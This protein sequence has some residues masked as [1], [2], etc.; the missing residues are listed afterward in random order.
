[1]IIRTMEQ[2]L[3]LVRQLVQDFKAQEA[4]YLSPQYQESQVRQDFIDKFFTALGWDVTHQRQKNPYEQ[5]AKIENRVRTEGSQRF[6]DYA[7]FIAPNYR[8]VKFFVEAKK[9]AH[10]LRNPTYYHQAI[11]YGWNQKTPIAILTD[12]EEFHILDCRYKPDIKT[13][14]DRKIEVYHYADY[15]DEETFK[16][17]FFLFGRD[18]VANG[19]LENYAGA[20]PRP[21]GK[22]AKKGI[23]KGGY[24]QVDE[25]FLELLDGYRD[26]LAHAFK[27]KNAGLDGEALTEAVQRTLDRLVFVRFLEDKGIEDPTVINY[28]YNVSAWNA[29]L[30]HRGVLEPKYNGLV[31]K[32]HPVIDSPTFIPP[33]DDTFGDIC[34]EL[35]D[36][37]SPYD[38]NSIP[39]SI[40][41]SIYERFLGKVVTTTDKR[42]RVIE[43]PEVRKAGGVYYT[44]EYIV[45]YIVSETLGKLL[46]EE[47]GIGDR[48]QGLGIIKG[49]G[50]GVRIVQGTGSVEEGDAS[51]GRGVSAIRD[52]SEGG[53]IWTEKSD[54]AGSGLDSGKHRGG[55][56]EESSGGLPP[57]SFDSKGI[58]DG[59]GDASR[60]ISAP[61]VPGAAAGRE[62]SNLD[63]GSRQ[64]AH[65]PDSISQET[66]TPTPY[67][68][69]PT[70]YTLSFR[71]TPA[72]VAKLRIADI[73]C[74]SGSFLLEVY[75][76]LLDYHT[77]YYTEHPQKAKK[78]DTETREGKIVLSHRKRQEILVNN[79]YGVDIDFQATEVTQLSLYLKLMEDVTM[80]DAFQFSLLKE[81]MLPDLRRN[82]VC[83]NSL[84]G[85]DIV[86][87]LHATSVP[88]FD[89]DTEHALKPMNFEDAF[90][91]IMK[92]GGFDV[93]V[94][95]PPYI[96]IQALQEFNP[97]I[98][99]LLKNKYKSAAKGNYDIYV[100]FVERA[101]SFLNKAGLLGYILP[102]KF[103]NAQYGE[104][105][106]ELIASGK[107]L[108]KIV[109]FG[110][111]QVFKGAMTYTCL[112][113]LQS[114]SR[115]EIKVLKVKNLEKW[116]NIGEADQGQIHSDEI[117]QKEWNFDV[118][119]CS[120]L[121][122]KLR[123]MP[124]K[125]KDVADRIFQ[126]LITGADPVFIISSEG[127][128]F[129]SEAT[130]KSHK[131]ETEILHPL[132]KGSLNI[133]RYLI[134]N[135]TKS[136][137]FP[138]K[139]V[140]G[141]AE[142]LSVKELENDLPSVWSYLRE[143]K[144]QLEDRE[145]GK[146]K[147]GRWY[148]F[149]RSQNLGE[150]EQKKILTPSIASQASFTLDCK[151]SYY[152]VGSGGG[153]GGGYGITLRGDQ[154]ISYEYVLGLLNSRLLD[155]FLKSY[156]S[157]FS[158]G[159]Y[160]YNRQ[161]IEE[162]PIRTINFDDAA[163]K[164]RHDQI[165]T[166]VE[167]ML[168]AKEKHA[169]ATTEAEKNRLD[170]QIESLDRQIDE[171][172]YELYGLTEEERKIVEGGK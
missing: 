30:R 160:A 115:N 120:L 11:R 136:I 37:T 135:V 39:I 153:G 170:I 171:A 94:G 161:Y 80:N 46:Y 55:I 152:F 95:N 122:D 8:D 98:V 54:A 64:N 51:G 42:A 147:H 49:E 84:I 150:M 101:L 4:A 48:V 45:R 112:L 125:L 118:G 67:T 38:F 146:W 75:S 57:S 132:C 100:V 61:Q 102:H 12:F 7:F 23:A 74:G 163:D 159:F 142:L 68:L 16:K 92:G 149:G 71:L 88:M 73:A 78:G 113:F 65:A 20:L 34:D 87:T 53:A 158:G 124:V 82:I 126:G 137:L 43:K 168:K 70:P 44:P 141:K 110:D 32:E 89:D 10:D 172:V 26:T 111:Q 156:S 62:G 148:A 96:R 107:H 131:L 33:D 86:Q 130:Q 13:V 165:V 97:T 63:T 76:Q 9:P 129:F 85:R 25:A 121:F 59:V 18:A 36:P 72:E 91:E 123:Q 127:D 22:A 56:W 27:N 5:E 14:L 24:Q 29:F 28:R 144:A 139:L 83:G 169:A 138:Y 15:A 77:R 35:A 128:G 108:S 41:G 114:S 90:P 155:R 103:F 47:Q 166:L 60:D 19:S 167:Q 105:L 79:I 154:T 117:S 116:K 1:M 157:Q 6:A 66:L 93:V 52:S 81:R 162:L 109:H 164:A 104:S 3:A 50:H 134:S 119:E 151:G 40:L 99:E 2:S 31:F 106:R 69:H 145:R 140:S 58:V 133:R 21:R 17:I 143:N